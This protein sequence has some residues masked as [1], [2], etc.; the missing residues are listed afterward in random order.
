M[1][2]FPIS[3]FNFLDRRCRHF[4]RTFYQLLQ[5]IYF[6]IIHISKRFQFVGNFISSLKSPSISV[7]HPISSKDHFINNILFH[8]NTNISV[9]PIRKIS[10]T[11][12]VVVV[13][14]STLMIVDLNAPPVIMML[15]PEPRVCD[16]TNMVARMPICHQ[17]VLLWVMV[18]SS[19]AVCLMAYMRFVKEFTWLDFPVKK[20]TL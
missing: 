5:K 1:Q 8:F 10:R 7:H 14:N 20:F 18:S 2:K 17:Y 11:F 6:N 19:I 3:S 12:Q 15:A 16:N 4:Q 13:Y 9:G